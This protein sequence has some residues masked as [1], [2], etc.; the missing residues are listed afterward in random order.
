M[1]VANEEPSRR[2]NIARGADDADASALR[3]EPLWQRRRVFDEH[4]RVARARVDFVRGARDRETDT[5]SRRSAQKVAGANPKPAALA[6]ADRTAKFI[7][8]FDVPH[9]LHDAGVPKNEAGEIAGTV[10]HHFGRL[11]IVDR[12]V[13][14]KEIVALLEASY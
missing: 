5:E 13:T 11:N 8:R 10:E 12:P 4:P 6:C 1:R 2:T 3:D 9:T 7:A 14:Q